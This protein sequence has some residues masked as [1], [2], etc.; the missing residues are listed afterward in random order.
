MPHWTLSTD[1]FVLI[2]GLLDRI[3]AERLSRTSS[4]AYNVSRHAR[5]RE[6][7]KTSTSFHFS[8]ASENSTEEKQAPF[9]CFEFPPPWGEK[10]H[11][12]NVVIVFDGIQTV[13]D[14]VISV[15]RLDSS[16]FVVRVS[17]ETPCETLFTRLLNY[18]DAYL[19]T[20]RIQFNCISTPIIN[21]V[22]KWCY[23]KR[24]K[25]S[26]LN[27]YQKENILDESISQYACLLCVEKK[28][29]IAALVTSSLQQ[30]E[31]SNVVAKVPAAF[32]AANMRDIMK[33]ATHFSTSGSVDI[34][35][36]DF[37]QW[38]PKIFVVE[39]DSL[40]KIKSKSVLEWIFDKSRNGQNRLHVTLPA[41]YVKEICDSVEARLESER[42]HYH[43][44]NFHDPL[45]GS[46][47]MMTHLFV[48]G[49]RRICLE[50]RKFSREGAIRFTAMESRTSAVCQ[51]W[52]KSNKLIQEKRK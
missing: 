38:N 2:Y 18:F 14:Q 22:S 40:Q 23:S 9:V 26:S 7:E 35:E 34:E 8:K 1:E 21:A 29:E 52:K 25:C 28:T 4:F 27:F 47:R 12:I 33:F 3:S 45:Y 44:S 46:Q 42:P 51:I 15:K 24:R 36:E 31:A 39:N 41:H 49:I 19:T 30:I 17:R 5:L 20:K 48:H 50:E 13:F 6:L 16:N 32:S 37:R 43:Y 11:N 10:T